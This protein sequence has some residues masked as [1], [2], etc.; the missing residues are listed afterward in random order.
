MY[1]PVRTTCSR[2]G[3]QCRVENLSSVGRLCVATQVTST[4]N[5]VLIPAPYQIVLVRLAEGVV[6]RAPSLEADPWLPAETAY[7]KPLVLSP[8]GDDAAG[9]RAAITG[10]QASRTP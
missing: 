8:G 2:C 6:V 7:L 4:R 9:T 1:H 5:G 3:G 10:I